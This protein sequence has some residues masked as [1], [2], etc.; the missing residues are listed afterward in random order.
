MSGP[1]PL[2]R[3]RLLGLAGAAAAGIATG[4]FVTWR[5]AQ[6][7][8]AMSQ[9]VGGGSLGPGATTSTAPAGT[10]S[11]PDRMSTTTTTKPPRPRTVPYS[12]VAGE[13]F[14]E[15]K[16][17]GVRVVETLMTYDP[18]D[19]LRDVVERATDRAVGPLDVDALTGAIRPLFLP[20]VSSTAEVVYP[21]LGGLD[22]HRDP[23]KASIMVVALQRLDDG[24][25]VSEVS[26]CLD[27]R[28][29]KV[30][31]A[32][33]FDALADT[34]GVPVGRP[35]ALGEEAERVL[36]HPRIGMPDSVRWD[37]YDG[38]VDP[39]ILTALADLADRTSIEI[40]TCRRGHPPNVFHTPNPSAHGVGRAVD[41][42]AVDDLPVVQQR[43]DTTSTAHHVAAD[44]FE[45]GQ[46]HRLGS[47]WSFGGGGRS[48]TDP[49]HQDHLHLGVSA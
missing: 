5:L 8:T 45:A 19:T 11:V 18:D 12:P 25:T 7:P 17:G 32:W 48:W 26:R 13:V 35:P 44:L 47:P 34:S 41:I 38:I 6:T 23:E 15:A 37:I 46:I 30:D 42:W 16:L 49:V 39:R 27:V 36:A 24:S 3:R 33:G 10:N 40:T 9:E 21:Q 4:G 2:S 20:G 28:V 14:V 22:P 31:G 1:D 43:H 29:R